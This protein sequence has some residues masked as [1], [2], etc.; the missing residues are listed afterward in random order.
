MCMLFFLVLLETLQWI[1]KENMYLEKDWPS[2]FQ[3]SHI[4]RKTPLGLRKVGVSLGGSVWTFVSE[5]GVRKR[6]WEGPEEER[7]TVRVQMGAVV[8]H[9]QPRGSRKALSP[10]WTLCGLDSQL[11]WNTISVP[12]DT[13]NDGFKPPRFHCRVFFAS[14]SKYHSTGSAQTKSSLLRPCQGSKPPRILLCGA[15]LDCCSYPYR[16]LF[17]LMHCNQDR[18]EWLLFPPPWETGS[19]RKA[20]WPKHR[21]AAL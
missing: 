16:V 17:A 12:A 6:E 3:P 21:S 1:W 20:H 13:D 10:F 8:G 9:Y 19:R 5:K 11:Y 4:P 7:K 15:P 18:C 14:G 2:S